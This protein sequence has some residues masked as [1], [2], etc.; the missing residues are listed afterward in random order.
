MEQRAGRGGRSG[1][2]AMADAADS[3]QTKGVNRLNLGT[4]NKRHVLADARRVREVVFTVNGEPLK[5]VS[6]LKY[7]GRPISS[8]ESD[9]PAVYYN[10]KKTRKR[11][12]WVSRV[13]TQEGADSRVC[14]MFYKAVVQSILLYGCKTWFITSQVLSVLEGFHHRM[15]RCLSGKRPYYL[16]REDQWA[17]PPIAEV[18]EGAS[19]YPIKRYISVRQNTLVENIAT[20]PILDLCRETERLSRSAARLTLWWTQDMVEWKNYS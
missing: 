3:S 9:W 15:A 2:L 20:R 6:L 12:A 5:G 7:L 10:L 11:W 8:L 19:L 4:Y 13:L 18:L 1:F 14:G 16:P 17:Y